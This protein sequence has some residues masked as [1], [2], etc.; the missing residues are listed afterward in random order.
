MS[1]SD[2]WAT[3]A[4]MSYSAAFPPSLGSAGAGSGV[5]RGNWHKDSWIC[6]RVDGIATGR[7]LHLLMN[8]R[9]YSDR[10]LLGMEKG[11][12]LGARLSHKGDKNHPRVVLT[13]A[14]SRERALETTGSHG[15]HAVQV[16]LKQR[17]ACSFL[18]NTRKNK[19]KELKLELGS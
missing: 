18:G 13:C 8:T 16:P 17:Q 6:A 2:L 4:N 14:N 19:W 9:G 1:P 12:G 5:C 10:W 11:A 15:D 7:V 3:T